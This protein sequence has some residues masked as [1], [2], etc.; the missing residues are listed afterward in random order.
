MAGHHAAGPKAV[1]RP[2]C[3]DQLEVLARQ[4]EIGFYA[5]RASK[6]VPAIGRAGLAAALAAGA[7][8]YCVKSSDAAIVLDAVRTVAAGGAYLASN[9]FGVRFSGSSTALPPRISFSARRAP[10][11]R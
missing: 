3:F 7:D 9:C 2:Q 10:C 6:D 1:A 8:A 11:E 4:A 5:D